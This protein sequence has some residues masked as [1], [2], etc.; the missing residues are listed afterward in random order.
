MFEWKMANEKKI[1]SR[2]FADT[3]KHCKKYELS[4]EKMSALLG[5]YW[6]THLFNTSL[7]MLSFEMVY[8]FF[9]ELIIRHSVLVRQYIM[10]ILIFV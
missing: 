6:Y 9:R 8:N 3:A 1:M 2:L 7:S 4:D 10:D 5:I